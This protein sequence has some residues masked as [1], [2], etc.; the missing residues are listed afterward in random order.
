MGHIVRQ[1]SLKHTP[2]QMSLKFSAHCWIYVVMKDSLLYQSY[3]L[4]C[5]LEQHETLCCHLNSLKTLIHQQEACTD[6]SDDAKATKPEMTQ[7]VAKFKQR[8]DTNVAK[9]DR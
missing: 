2:F 8:Y 7:Y 3:G 4:V 9:R 5:C 6:S 1:P